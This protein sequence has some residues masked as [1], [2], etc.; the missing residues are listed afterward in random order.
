MARKRSEAVEFIRRL[1][2]TKEEMKKQEEKFEQKISE[3]R[4][5]LTAVQSGR[6]TVFGEKNKL[7]REFAIGET[8]GG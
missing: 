6:V 3:F 8:F 5:D 4:E 1:R 7:R 2:R